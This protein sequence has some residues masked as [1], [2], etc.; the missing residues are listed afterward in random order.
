MINGA[1]MM[2]DWIIMKNCRAVNRTPTGQQALYDRVAEF[3]KAKSYYPLELEIIDNSV[4]VVV[5]VTPEVT[6]AILSEK[7]QTN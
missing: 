6:M 7:C 1:K 3:N 2:E 5:T 4:W